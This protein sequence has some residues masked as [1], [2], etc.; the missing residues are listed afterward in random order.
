MH[1]PW[2]HDIWTCCVEVI[3]YWIHFHIKKICN[4]NFKKN[5]DVHVVL[6]EISQWTIFYGTY[7]IRLGLLMWNILVFKLFLSLKTKINYQKTSIGRNIQLR[8]WSHLHVYHSIQ[9]WLL[10]IFD[11]SKMGYIPMLPGYWKVTW[12]STRSRSGY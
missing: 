1:L 4:C 8:M 10:F 6:L 11:S 2:F 9:V 5:W 7:F 12:F 3:E